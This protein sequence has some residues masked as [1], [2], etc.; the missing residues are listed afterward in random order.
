MWYNKVSKYACANQ[1][2]LQMQLPLKLRFLLYSDRHHTC[3]AYT[4]NVNRHKTTNPLRFP[5]AENSTRTGW[6]CCHQRKNHQQ[7]VYGKNNHPSL[8]AHQI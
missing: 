6:G 8:R 4:R 3:T 5:D 1:P 7:I 2:P